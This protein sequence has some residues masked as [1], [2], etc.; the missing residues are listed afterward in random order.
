MRKSVS[1]FSCGVLIFFLFAAGCPLRAQVS[2][3]SAWESFV[4][5]KD[6][7]VVSDTFRLQTFGKSDRDNWIYQADKNVLPPG[8]EHTLRIPAGSSV[9]F[10]PFRLSLYEKVEICVYFRG[11]NL[12]VNQTLQCQTYRNNQSETINVPLDN[13]HKNGWQFNYIKNN[14]SELTLLSHA[15]EEEADGAFL[16]DSVYATGN[17]LA[18]SLF[19]GSGDWNDTARW[20]HLPPLRN[21]CALIQGE[22]TVSTDTQCRDV[23][24]HSGS[25]QLL[26]GNAL[27]LHD[28]SLYG[29]EAFFRSNGTLEQSG[30]ITVHKT[31]EET[32][33]WYF[34][35]FPFDVYPA[36]IDSRFQQ[37]DELFEGSGN[38]FY[39]QRYDGDRRASLNQASGNWEVVPRH[40][41]PQTPLFEKNKGY[42]IALDSEATDRT[43]SF[44]SQVGGMP[45][46]FARVGLVPL[47]IQSDQ[48]AD[49]AANFGWFLCG[50]PLP[51]PLALS[52]IEANPA[53]DGNVY[54][55]DGQTY[56]TY[57]IRENPDYALPPFSAFFLK[58]SQET[59]LKVQAL[60][61]SAAQLQ[62]I[63]T[64]VF[65]SANPT[66]PVPSTSST[67][68]ETPCP[69]ELHISLTGRQLHVENL[70]E[71][72]LLR[73]YTLTGQCIFTR[74][75]TAGACTL[76][77]PGHTQGVYLLQLQSNRGTVTRK[78]YLPML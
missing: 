52:Q 22:T 20:S 63:R 37:Q 48:T 2:N 72:T 62:M 68:T 3:P 74:Q 70:P 49:N 44:T 23:A 55:F 69:D 16:F 10:T 30:R 65:L 58:A 38:Y 61:T 67:H 60:T 21:R 18:Y 12:T 73:L 28:L 50:N 25:L 29:D 43:L 6:N 40:T 46:D 14:P 45:E 54:V 42:L 27:S 8:K 34:I 24:I 35:S 71:N 66:E 13:L 1:N 76:S 77:L 51:A 9:A 64:G 32:G 26:T 5:S 7:P 31:F 78:L 36:G 19:S 4:N 11:E 57:S 56:Q 17:I 53:L 75:V 33:K 41:D 59:E 15:P 47:T 39:L